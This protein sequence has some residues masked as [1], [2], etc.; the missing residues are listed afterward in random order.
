MKKLW[1]ALI[2]F[3]GGLAHEV[4]NPFNCLCIT[5]RRTEELDPEHSGSRKRLL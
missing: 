5:A 2:F 3:A 1:F 4:R